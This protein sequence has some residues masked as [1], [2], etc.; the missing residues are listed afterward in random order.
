MS[1]TEEPLTKAV[2]AQLAFLTIYNP[3]LGTND[4]TLDDQIV[5]YTSKYARGKGHR[6]E[7]LSSEDRNE[8]LRQIG[9]A[10][11]MVDFGKNFSDGRSVDTIDT[12][13]SRIVLYELEVGWWILASIDL[14]RLPAATPGSKDT[15]V[16]ARP[17]LEYSSREVKP[18]ALLLQDIVRAHQKFLLH[19]ASS[20]SA[21][22]VRNQRQKFLGIFGRYWDSFTATW[23]VLLHG[24]PAVNI[25]GG[26]KLAAC[27]ELGIGVGE[28]ERG[29]GERAVL[30]ELASNIEG[31]VDVVVS[32]FGEAAKK[33]K[34]A[35]HVPPTR[36]WLGFGQEPS[37]EDGAIFLGVGALSRDSLRDITHWMEDIYTWG[38]EAY[39][40]LDNP[41]ST[42]RKKMRKHVL[43][44]ALPEPG[45]PFE[46]GE[47][48]SRETSGMSSRDVSP[49]SPAVRPNSLHRSSYESGSPQTAS[50]RSRIKDHTPTLRRTGSSGMSLRST[51]PADKFLS[52][53]KLGYGT[54]WSLTTVGSAS[55]EPEAAAAETAKI[56]NPVPAKVAF[57]EPTSISPSTD[58]SAVVDYFK[59]PDQNAAHYL[60]GLMGDLE[61]AIGHGHDG[62]DATL[63][64]ED[65]NARI[66]LRTLTVELERAGDVRA[67]ADISVDLGHCDSASRYGSERTGTSAHAS[68]ESQDRNKTKK[69]RVVVYV[70]RPFIYTLL[71]EQRT[72]SLAFPSLYRSLHTNLTSL[73]KP[74]LRSTSYRGPKPA[75]SSTMPSYKSAS[76]NEKSPI[77]DIVWDPKSLTI[78]SSLPDIP[79]PVPMYVE[80]PVWSR[81]E[82][83]NTHS[84]ILN[85]YLATRN[86]PC[87]YERTCKTARGYWV[88]W[89]RIPDPEQPKLKPLRLINRALSDGTIPPSSRSQSNSPSG[90]HPRNLTKNSP[91]LALF[92]GGTLLKTK[93]TNMSS[94]AHP[95]L[96][97][98][99]DDEGNWEKEI[100][101]VRKAAE[102]GD[103]MTGVGGAAGTEVSWM[104]GVGGGI[105]GIGVDT[106]RYIEGL[107]NLR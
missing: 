96:Y 60:V 61:H 77:Y 67:E 4:E 44:V 12:E 33:N 64:G 71:F 52:Y 22:F 27:G 25:Y 1:N 87:E 94:P 36:P 23:N 86:C 17:S 13:K 20:V 88:S 105:G 98:P 53:M 11:G 59:P 62:A 92:D 50:L 81:L 19:H 79:S 107:L 93:G 65:S 51:A 106:K 84:Q 5:Y 56:L 24:N 58:N 3:S 76:E 14:T 2:P 18:A 103:G 34:V 91:T 78:T 26:I 74:L 54:H 83:L 69:L 75:I 48:A 95:F 10:Q 21:L 66:L 101:L 37:H 8:R 68:F 100:F 47:E 82:A 45:L 9:L 28:E 90:L 89:T 70:S 41:S 40:V 39:G 97:F 80:K 72:D 15:S 73:Q 35:S 29:S 49:V 104:A 46:E 102:H 16:A 42:R 57:P 99:S 7:E 31:L 38:S 6:R 43:K 32:K 55:H 63:D 30:E 85:T